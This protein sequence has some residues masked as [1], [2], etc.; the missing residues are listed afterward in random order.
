M[1]LDL[2][3]NE[4]GNDGI[5]EKLVRSERSEDDVFSDAVA[6]FMDSGLSPG[7]KERL[8]EESLDSGTDVEGVHIKEQIL[9]G[10]SEHNV[11]NGKTIGFTL[12]S[13]SFY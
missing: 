8:Q 1:A 12:A 11:F 6:E 4:K 13:S 9:S 2:V 7:I 5:G 3:N 10:P